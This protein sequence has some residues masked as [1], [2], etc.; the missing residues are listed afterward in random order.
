MA[1]ITTV[2][3]LYDGRYLTDP[4][5]AVCYEVCQTY[6]EAKKERKEYGDDTFIVK[7]TLQYF[8]KNKLIH[9]SSEI[10]FNP[11]K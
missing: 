3:E 9:L 7:T 1:K 2:Y 10:A 11:N 6:A 4:D 8:S 5:R